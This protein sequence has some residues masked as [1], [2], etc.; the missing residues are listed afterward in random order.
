MDWSAIWGAI[1]GTASGSLV[2]GFVA[3]AAFS[4]RL[5]VLSNSCSTNQVT[6][7]RQHDTCRG[8]THDSIIAVKEELKAHQDEKNHPPEVFRLLLMSKLDG[9]ETRVV[10]IEQFLRGA[11]PGG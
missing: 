10:S 11:P 7:Q 6:M 3:W 8:E 9:I 1:A 2:T 4:N 5:A